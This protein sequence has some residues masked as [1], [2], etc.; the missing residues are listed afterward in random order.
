M[1]QIARRKKKLKASIQCLN[2]HTPRKKGLT[3]L[4]NHRCAFEGYGPNGGSYTRNAPVS[5][6]LTTRAIFARWVMSPPSN[7]QFSEACGL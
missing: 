2:C 6:Q 5:H 3:R 1:C 4:H 7:E